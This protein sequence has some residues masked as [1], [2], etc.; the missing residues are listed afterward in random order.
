MDTEFQVDLET[1]L[2]VEA[3]PIDEETA[4]FWRGLLEPYFPNGDAQLAIVGGNESAPLLTFGHRGGSFWIS[5]P[6]WR[7]VDGDAPVL[8]EEID[9][10]EVRFAFAVQAEGAI[11]GRVIGRGPLY[12]LSNNGI[13]SVFADKAQCRETLAALK[14]LLET[15]T[16]QLLVWRDRLDQTEARLR[17]KNNEVKVL[18][19]RYGEICRENIAQHE[20]LR[21]TNKL[22]EVRVRERTAE[23]R[24]AYAALEKQLTIIGDLQRSF[25]PSRFPP[26]PSY[27][28]APYYQPSEEAS[29][30]YFDVFP[31]SGSL[32]GVVVADVC[33]HGAP[34]AVMMA[35]VRILVRSRASE[36]SDPSDMLRYINDI[37]FREV[38]N[39]IF[40]TMV[41]TVLDTST[42]VMRYSSAGHPAPF[43]VHG[44]SRTSEPLSLAGDV[45]INLS[46]NRAYVSQECVLEPLDSVVFYTDGVT[47][48]FNPDGELFGEERLCHVLEQ[49]ATAPADQIAARIVDTAQAF[50]GHAPLKDDFTLLV[51]QRV[52][53][54]MSNG[55]GPNPA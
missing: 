17:Q 24:Q 12:P 19:D 10:H 23:L 29:G 51:L 14:R 11:Y 5:W 33:G 15:G 30:D 34:A 43:I 47:E 55:G 50:A 9:G 8:L 38:G 22:L 37:L 35:M 45:P 49:S 4:T 31:I 3:A 52:P 6:A 18:L 40:I 32:V 21:D 7:E 41:Y 1:L 54:E 46:P 13:R 20:R 53:D 27:V 28:W 26:H 42:G 39:F 48:V 2:G 25:L 36:F 16:A 44:E